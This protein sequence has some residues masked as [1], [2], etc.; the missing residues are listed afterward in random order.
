METLNVAE[1]TNVIPSNCVV[2][3]SVAPREALLLR[4]FS[5]SNVPKA[6]SN[7]FP[8]RGASNRRIA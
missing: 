7:E 5:T 4:K 1:A 2:A 3:A 6:L 8:G